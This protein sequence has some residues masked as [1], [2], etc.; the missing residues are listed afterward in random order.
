MANNKN[1]IICL[2][3]LIIYFDILL[4]CLWIIC[5]LTIFNWLLGIFWLMIVSVMIVIFCNKRLIFY[6]LMLFCILSYNLNHELIL[7]RV[8]LLFFGYI[9]HKV[10]HFWITLHITCILN[11]NFQNHLG[12]HFWIIL[13]TRNHLRREL[14]CLL[15]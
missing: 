8:R 15:L 11:D 13:H 7:E 9:N 6:F 4:I 12:C 2:W 1:T 5:C 14:L 10:S 3:V